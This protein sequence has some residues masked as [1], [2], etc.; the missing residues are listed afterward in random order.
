MAGVSP[1]LEAG[2]VARL[3]ARGRLALRPAEAVTADGREVLRR[4][5]C[6]AAPQGHLIYQGAPLSVVSSV[7]D[8]VPIGGHKRRR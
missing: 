1:Y 5:G 7:A 3:G 4:N 2:W 6:E 8:A